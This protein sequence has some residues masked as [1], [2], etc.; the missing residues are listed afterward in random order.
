MSLKALTPNPSPR[1]G[2]GS[3]IGTQSIAVTPVPLLPPWEKGLG[4]EG[5]SSLLLNS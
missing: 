3:R 2:E 5:K 1:T 4:D